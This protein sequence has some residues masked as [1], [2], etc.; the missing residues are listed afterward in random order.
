MASPPAV[1][2]ENISVSLHNG[3]TILTFFSPV[4]GEGGQLG[5]V[6]VSTVAL[7]SDATHNLI[8]LLQQLVM[9]ATTSTADESVE[10]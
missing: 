9:A 8:G 1:Y 4:A 6:P 5:V 2:V 3:M 7:R 10:N